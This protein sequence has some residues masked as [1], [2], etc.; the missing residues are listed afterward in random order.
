MIVVSLSYVAGTSTA[1]RLLTAAGRLVA[2][3]R[4]PACNVKYLVTIRISAQATQHTCSK[5]DGYIYYSG[6]AKYLSQGL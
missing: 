1:A 5:L 3:C 6:I 4:I 2:S